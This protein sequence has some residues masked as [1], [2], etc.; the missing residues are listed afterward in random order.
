MTVFLSHAV[1]KRGGKPVAP[2]KV[3]E[4]SFRAGF[5]GSV[6]V[7]SLG[8]HVRPHIIFITCVYCVESRMK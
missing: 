1:G 6:R 3:T 2:H 7:A 4:T 8:V 5:I